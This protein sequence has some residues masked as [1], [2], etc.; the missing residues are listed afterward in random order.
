M[1]I[2][3]FIRYEID[4]FQRDAFKAYAENWGQIIPRC[5][6]HLIG[7][8]LPYEGTNNVAWG[9]IA[10]DSLATYE[11]YRARLKSDEG[12]HANFTMAQEK[13]FILKEE[14]SFVEVVDGTLGVESVYPWSV[15]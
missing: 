5:G 12:G 7:Y 10:F 14:R 9:L 2:T 8:F 15:L 3:C 4:P 11:A 13:K 6:G 1:S